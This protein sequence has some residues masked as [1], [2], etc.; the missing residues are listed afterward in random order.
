MQNEWHWIETQNTQNLIQVN[1]NPSS[2]DDEALRFGDSPESFIAIVWR[3]WLESK[4]H[5]FQIVFAE[6]AHICAKYR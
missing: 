3:T 4:T 5:F 2:N 1:S 6:T